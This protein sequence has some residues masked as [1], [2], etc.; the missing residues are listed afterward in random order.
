MKTI[1]YLLLLFGT[2][3]LATAG[4]VDKPTPAGINSAETYSAQ[5]FT[6]KPEWKKLFPAKS[7]FSI[8]EGR[9][10]AQFATTSGEELYRTLCQACHMENGQGASG[11]GEYP[12]FV[13]NKRLRS[14]YYPI[15]VVLNGL[16]GM[17]DFGDMLSNEQVA[18]VVNYLRTNFGNQ[19]AGDATAEDVARVRPAH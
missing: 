19:L 5:D 2:V 18:G 12:S 3:G 1:A 10:P 16:R 11:A 4:S 7:S 6:V 9:K 14:V 13:G 17:R 15:D 8:S